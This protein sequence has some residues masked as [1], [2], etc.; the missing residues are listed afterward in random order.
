MPPR[1]VILL[2]VEDDVVMQRVIAHHLKTIREFA[3]EIVAVDGE[4]A[5]MA[6]FRQ[7]HIDL[8]ILD[9]QLAQGNGLNLLGR[10]REIAPVIPIIAIS[11]V[12]TEEV[13]AELVH[14]GADDYFDK[15]ELD[16]AK[17]TKSVRAVLLRADTLA[18]QTAKMS[19]TWNE[20]EKHLMELCSAYVERIGAEMLEKL[21][22]VADELRQTKLGDG[23][24]EML[25]NRV[26]IE[27][28]RRAG[29][30]N[31]RVLLRPL[32]LDLVFRLEGDAI[33]E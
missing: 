21:A 7:K 3:F 15:R 1:T 23:E 16:S 22:V 12:A 8:V 17:L 4:D 18:K 10:L 9:Y 31:A 28:Q 26:C 6:A 20:I 32:F 29:S 13:A 25:C 11:G 14:A 2:H 19:D 30:S 24:F 27:A 5:A 33:A